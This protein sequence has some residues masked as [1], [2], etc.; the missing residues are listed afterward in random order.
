VIMQFAPFDRFPRFR[1]GSD[2]SGPTPGAGTQGSWSEESSV[3][4]SHYAGFTSRK[5]S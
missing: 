5:Y 4:C 2:C 1:F 3:K